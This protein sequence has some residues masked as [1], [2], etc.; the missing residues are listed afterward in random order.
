MQKGPGK[1]SKES[2]T[3]SEWYLNMR[4]TGL[5]VILGS[6]LQAEDQSRQG[7]PSSNVLPSFMQNQVASDDPQCR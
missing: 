5:N 1:P 6:E 3:G 4:G 7:E 2:L